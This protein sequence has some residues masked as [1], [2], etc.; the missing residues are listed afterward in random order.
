MHTLVYPPPSG[1][2][3]PR[4]VYHTNTNSLIETYIKL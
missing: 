2:P 1:V 4:V 3:A